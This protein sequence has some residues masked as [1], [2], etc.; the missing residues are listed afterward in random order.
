M[1]KCKVLFVSHLGSLQGGADKSLFELVTGIDKQKIQPS[2]LLPSG[3]EV[4]KDYKE[5]EIQVITSNY[6]TWLNVKHQYIRARIRIL[7]NQANAYRLAISLSSEHIHVVYSN[8]LYTPFGAYLAQALGVPHIWHAREIVSRGLNRFYDCG[9]DNSLNL[10]ANMSNKVICNSETLFHY[11]EPY[12]S[13]E[14]LKVVYN[15]IVTN[16]LLRQPR[17]IVRKLNGLTLCI[18]GRLTKQKGQDQAIAALARLVHTG[19]I[20]T[21]H[22]AGVGESEPE[23][24]QQAVTL[25]VAEHIKWHGFINPQTLY[26]QCDINLVCAYSEGFGRTVV[27]AMASGC[28]TIGADSGGVGEII[29]DGINGLLYNHGNI[30][31]LTDAIVR[32]ANDD[33]LYAYISKSGIEIAQ[34]KYSLS[35]HIDRITEIILE[36]AGKN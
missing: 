22:I 32:L 36:V 26:S 35:H 5:H 11:L 10:V 25:G 23:L 14:K 33:Q 3:S 17:T 13:D 4:I 1:E 27:E 8:T 21:L 30:S 19:H 12:V 29:E 7:F 20:A 15:G 18:I 28:P 6:K 2:I 24:R 34:N 31:Q 9:E 16:Q